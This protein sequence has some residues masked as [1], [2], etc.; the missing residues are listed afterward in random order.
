[1]VMVMGFNSSTYFDLQDHVSHGA[2][3]FSANGLCSICIC[4]TGCVDD[5]NL[6]TVENGFSHKANTDGLVAHMNH[7]AQI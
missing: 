2:T 4:M 1:M 7:D 5:N 3:Y 6:Q